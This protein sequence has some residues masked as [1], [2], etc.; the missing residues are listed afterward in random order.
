M[1]LVKVIY[2]YDVIVYRWWTDRNS[3]RCV[4][5]FVGEVTDDEASKVRYHGNRFFERGRNQ[6]AGI[7][8]CRL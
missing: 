1:T 4:V 2:R 8:S 3:T 6:S 5:F 7:R